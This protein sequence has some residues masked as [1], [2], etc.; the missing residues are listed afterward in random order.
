MGGGGDY[1]PTPGGPDQIDCQ[2]LPTVFGVLGCLIALAAAAVFSLGSVPQLHYGIKYNKFNKAATTD[3][4]YEP[5]R[6]LIGPFNT[7]LLF[8]SSAQ[9]VEFISDRNLQ[10][11]GVRYESLQTRTK[12]GFGL[13][14]QVA[15]QYRLQKDKV[16]DLYNTFNQGYQ[17]VFTSV[18]RDTLIKAASEYNA[19]QLW[20]ERE[21]FATKMQNMIDAE[22]RKN[23]ATCWSL[24]LT[25]IDLPDQFETKLTKTQVQEQE[26]LVREQEQTSAKIHAQTSVIEA[27]YKRKVKVLMAEGSANYTILTREAEAQ[28]RQ[29]RIETESSILKSIKEKL[30]MDAGDL[31]TYQRYGALDDLVNASILFGFKAQ[32]TPVKT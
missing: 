22:L 25:I 1:V 8:P 10:T 5:G 13:K 18:A 23:Y 7:F 32:Q 19:V 12:E 31:V 11:D 24:Q 9:N 27:E 16:G 15:F 29:K 30:Q 14:L 20:K 28:A 21:N 17:D 4:V 26:I 2:S 6:H 3:T